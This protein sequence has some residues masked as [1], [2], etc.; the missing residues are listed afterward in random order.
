MYVASLE[1][2]PTAFGNNMEVLRE[3]G[4]SVV[5]E[6]I[7]RMRFEQNTTMFSSLADVVREEV[8]QVVREPQQ[9]VLPEV[10]LLRQ[11]TTMS[12]ADALQRG[13][14]VHANVAAAAPMHPP[15][16]PSTRQR[17]D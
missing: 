17:G 1:P 13:T 5:R 3:L 10:P 12:Y 14:S 6:E 8:R 2:L 11:P 4:R 16:C 7:Q 15:M 9:R